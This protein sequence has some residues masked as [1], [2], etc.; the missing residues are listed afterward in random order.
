MIAVPARLVFC[1]FVDVYF[2]SF[3]L[4]SMPLTFFAGF[5]WGFYEL[6]SFFS[7]FLFFACSSIVF[8]VSADLALILFNLP[9]KLCFLGLF[10]FGL[11]YDSIR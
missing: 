9:L 10:N 8:H 5:F 6:T 11:L 7:A 3:P 1:V 4:L 2:S